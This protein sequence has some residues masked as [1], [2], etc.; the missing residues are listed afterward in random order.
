M[1]YIQF[2]YNKIYYLFI[3]S[4]VIYSI[5]DY[6][7]KN[8]VINE[9]HPSY[10]IFLMYLGES[11]AGIIY[12]YLKYSVNEKEERISTKLFN[13]INERFKS[14]GGDPYKIYFTIFLAAMID[15]ISYY[16]Y[17]Y[18]FNYNM[19]KF[20]T[21]FDDLDMIFQCIFLCINESYYLNLP[22]YKH[23][24]LGLFLIF[25]S[26]LI[27]MISNLIKIGIN[28]IFYFLLLFL[29]FIE[30]Q[31]L[32]SLL[33]TLEKIVNYRYFVSIYKIEFIEGLSGLI[34]ILSLCGIYSIFDP[35]YFLNYFNKANSEL[36]FYSFIYIF[37]VLFYNLIRLRII[38][39]KSPS[40][41][42]IP[43][44]LAVIV[45]DI[46]I[47]KREFTIDFILYSIF[48]LLGACIFSEVI[49][50][51]FFNLDR[52]TF[53]ETR[54]RGKK[55]TLNILYNQLDFNDDFVLI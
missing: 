50:F 36:F 48:S 43:N 31:C 30:S 53:H 29:N 19:L 27:V 1:K 40:Y 45:I 10:K 52:N 8:S 20:N 9:F 14:Q 42:I 2:H 41:N 13:S 12:L 15:G 7:K 24:Y 39:L 17:K 16:N 46:F 35:N 37:L 6:L 44:I 28:N 34:F 47:N 55:E 18:Y 54:K 49:T 11:L 4:I 23:H 5:R 25:L 51:K 21:I 32:L 38:E 22:K 33:Y 3:F 26:L